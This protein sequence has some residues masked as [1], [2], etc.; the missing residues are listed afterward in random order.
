MS[1]IVERKRKK[2]KLN[3]G[4][5]QVVTQLEKAKVK[6][7]FEP[8]S[9]TYNVPTT[10]T[11][12]FKVETKTGPLYIEVKGYHAGMQQWCAKIKHFTQQNPKISF[13]MVF[14]DASKKFNKNYKSNLGDW[15][16]KNNIEW[17]DKG[18]IP[19]SWLK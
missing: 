12:D 6:Y 10:Y 1:K 19:S 14:L 17:S 15:A 18:K 13:K 16:T 3:K 7:S 2:L 9:F 5:L 11:P 8:H 4:E